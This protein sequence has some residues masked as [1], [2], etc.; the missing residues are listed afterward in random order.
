[1]YYLQEN[2][3]LTERLDRHGKICLGG[4]IYQILPPET[5][6]F[7]TNPEG[8]SSSRIHIGYTRC[9][10]QIRYVLRLADQLG[11]D[12]PFVLKIVLEVTRP[13]ATLHKRSSSSLDLEP[14]HLTER[15]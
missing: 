15:C 4:K 6:G 12:V 13:R 2:N 8:L 7:K 11:V 5:G 9:F 10:N 1:M 3:K 14:E